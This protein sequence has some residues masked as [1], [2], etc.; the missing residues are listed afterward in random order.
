MP[1]RIVFLFLAGIIISCEYN[2][3]E[4]DDGGRG[5]WTPHLMS[6]LDD[7]QTTLHWAKPGCLLC[8]TCI[9]PQTNPDYFQILLS[10]GSAS[11][12]SVFTTVDS[13]TFA[14]VIDELTNGKPYYFAVRAVKDGLPATTS[15][16]IMTVP[17]VAGNV[18]PQF[19]TAGFDRQ[20]GTWSP[21]GS[22]VAYIRN[23]VWDNG[24]RSAQSLF[25]SGLS[26]ETEELVE[27]HSR[28]PQWS[29]DGNRIVYQ[30]HNGSVK[31]APGY[32]PTH[33]AMFDVRDSTARRL[34]GGNTFDFLPA[35]SPDGKWVAFLSDRGDGMEYNIWKIP[36]DSGA[37]VQITTGFN[38]LN[39]LGIKDDRSPEKPAWSSDGDWIA[40][41]R[42]TKS[43]IGYNNDIYAVP[44][45]GGN[46]TVVVSSPW[47]EYCPA[48]SADGTSIAFVSDR[49]GSN[50]IWTMNLQ[51]KKLKQITGSADRWIDAYSGVE[52]SASG[53]KILFTASQGGYYSLYAVE[54]E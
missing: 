3:I 17:G 30:T 23:H 39:E 20:M 50:Q 26:D 13:G 15:M 16:T 43:D 51:T 47:G 32:W 46:R 44:L 42:L 6:T 29:P 45:N 40:F 5:L 10:T 49:S 31:T 37:V 48:Y 9:C 25:V 53:D 36:A 28:N 8:G 4:I 38:D 14:A 12:L 34:T 27:I 52:W 35:W 22:S 24:N 7:G 19:A 21:D 41:A 54:T 33:I 18:I 2:D 11:D 1:M